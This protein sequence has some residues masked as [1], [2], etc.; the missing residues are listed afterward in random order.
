[1]RKTRKQNGGNM[2]E[3][4]RRIDKWVTDRDDDKFL[5]L[6]Y[7]NLKSLPTLPENLGLV[8]KLTCF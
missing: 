1:M 7:L 8:A 3:A 4:Q 5:D 2:A 6:S